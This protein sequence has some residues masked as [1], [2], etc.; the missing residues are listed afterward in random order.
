MEAIKDFIMEIYENIHK[1]LYRVIKTG[2][3][4]GIEGANENETVLVENLTADFDKITEFVKVLNTEGLE[5][6]HLNE[7]RN[8]RF[9]LQRL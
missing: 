3:K 2:S 1:P 5:L 9:R 6:C 4:Y 7:E 8:L